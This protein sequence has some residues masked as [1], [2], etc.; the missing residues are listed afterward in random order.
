[1]SRL[2]TCDHLQNHPIKF[3]YLNLKRRRGVNTQPWTC[4]GH[5]QA[6]KCYR[7]DWNWVLLKTLLKRITGMNIYVRMYVHSSYICKLMYACMNL[8]C[9]YTCTD[10]NKQIYIY[11]CVCVCVCADM[12]IYPRK[13]IT[14]LQSLFLSNVNREQIK[15][16]AAFPDISL[17]IK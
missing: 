14:I 7:W 17:E 5:R 2:Y 12:R 16:I 3:V 13:Y 8:L 1:M 6:R 4:N 11:V 15:S 10:T 9:I